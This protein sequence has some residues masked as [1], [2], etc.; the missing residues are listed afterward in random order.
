M[1]IVS[2]KVNKSFVEQSHCKF[3]FQLVSLNIQNTFLAQKQVKNR[4]A[5]AIVLHRLLKQFRQ[6][7]NFYIMLT[8]FVFYA[9]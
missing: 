7:I 9:I 4:V 6:V 8:L 2:D 1:K 5:D 3:N